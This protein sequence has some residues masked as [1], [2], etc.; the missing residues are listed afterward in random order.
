[1]RGFFQFQTYEEPIQAVVSDS[2]TSIQVI[3]AA[4]AVGKYTAV[5]RKRITD[6]TRGGLVQ[7]RALEIVATHLGPKQSRLKLL[8]KDFQSLG[9]DGSGTF[10]NP[11]PIGSKP[12]ISAA[13][14]QLGELRVQAY[15]R[16]QPQ[17][18]SHDDPS[19]S[20]IRSQAA[21]GVLDNDE[22]DA[23]TQAAFAT[24][25]KRS[26]YKCRSESGR[27]PEGKND[28]ITTI[29]NSPPGKPSVSLSRPRVALNSDRKALL[30]L[31][32]SKNKLGRFPMSNVIAH[33]SLNQGLSRVSA[34]GIEDSI[35]ASEKD[36]SALAPSLAHNE[37]SGQTIV[38]DRDF[39]AK[40]P[41]ETKALQSPG[42]VKDSF[43]K[44]LEIAYPAT[45]ISPSLIVDSRSTMHQSSTDLSIERPNRAVIESFHILPTGL[46]TSPPKTNGTGNDDEE[47]PWKVCGYYNCAPRY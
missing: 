18:D 41:G 38:T 30:D 7:I 6:G 31:L 12:N 14:N 39:M 25:S 47:H 36:N 19:A 17:S 43:C 20:G 5:A 27:P 9:C 2:Q 28:T 42:S 3:F 8:I 46:D 16:S 22:A 33:P 10:G 1:M 23:V 35:K 13:L 21:D 40:Q 11:V 32:T 45:S 4:S 24:Q 15:T 37:A 44:D 26:K 34:Q 29:T